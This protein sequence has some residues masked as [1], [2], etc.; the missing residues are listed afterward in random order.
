MTVELAPSVQ[1]ALDLFPEQKKDNF[2]R[3]MDVVHL[4][5]DGT[6][7]TVCSCVNGLMQ[8]YALMQNQKERGKIVKYAYGFA[9]TKAKAD[10]EMRR[11]KVLEQRQ[12]QQYDIQKQTLT[13]YVDRQYQNA[14]DELT[15]SFQMESN[16]TEWER[17]NFIREIDRYTASAI[18][19]MDARYQQLLRQEEVICAAYRDVLHDLKEQGIS[20]NQVAVEML[21]QA[22]LNLDKLNDDN[23]KVMIDAITKM[24]EPSF[25]SFEDFVRMHGEFQQRRLAW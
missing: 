23:F 8:T 10:V 6:V 21:N 4:C 14:V 11:L 3:F 9:E 5:M 1:A 19:G 20:R 16:K 17:Y 18:S 13:L 2:D 15:K 25:I 7:G 12:W 24:T 22:M